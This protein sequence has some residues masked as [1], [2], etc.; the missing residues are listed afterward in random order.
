MYNSC[1]FKREITKPKEKGEFNKGDLL[2]LE[3]NWSFL[4]N[5]NIKAN[6][7]K[8]SVSGDILYDSIVPVNSN[9]LFDEKDTEYVNTK[10]F[11]FIPKYYY[12][13][14]IKG[15]NDRLYLLGHLSAYNKKKG[16]PVIPGEIV[17]YVGNTGNSAGAHLHLEVFE[18]SNEL[19][20]ENIIN[21]DASETIEMKWV[22]DRMYWTRTASRLN[23][24]NH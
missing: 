24:F 11:I 19:E 20:K 4:F 1:I 15:N 18:C 10:E 9:S 3:N 22:D 12:E 17:A 8:T 5:E 23:P 6:L 2:N 13:I 7:L 21:I 14:L 16:D